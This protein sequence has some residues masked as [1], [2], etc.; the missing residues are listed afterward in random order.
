MAR[1]VKEQEYRVK[2]GAI[3]DAAR[4]LVQTKGYEQ[5]AIQDVLDDLQISK[6]AFYHYFGSKQALLEALIEQMLDEGQQFLIAITQD[7]TLSALEKL[8]RFFIQLAQWKTAQKE[9]FLGLLRV[10]YADEN[11][12]VRHKLQ[13][14][15][16][17][18][19]T[20]WLSTVIRQGT[21]TKWP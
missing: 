1:P 15:R 7:P 13:E 18:R 20:P 3:L 6:G 9:T 14:A 4:R 2:R 17:K 8:Q 16:I 19:V 10:W 21:R 12:L 11:A 5:M